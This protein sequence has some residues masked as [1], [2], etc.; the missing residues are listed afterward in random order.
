M[1]LRSSL[2]SL[3][4]DA[5]VEIVP[6]SELESFNV[7]WMGKYRGNSKVVLK[8]KTTEEVSKIVKYCHDCNLAIVPQ[9][10]NTGLVGKRH[11]FSFRSL[12]R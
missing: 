6:E 2:K 10:G 11:H 7:D 5:N 8:P 9:G 12:K 1:C 3:G 4:C